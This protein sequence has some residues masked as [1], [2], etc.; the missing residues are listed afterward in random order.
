M[1]VIIDPQSPGA[2]AAPASDVIKDGDTQS[3]TAD[4]IEASTQIPVIVDFWAPWCGPCKQLGPML[5]KLVNQA[6]G[7]VRLVKINID[8]NK[9]LAAQLRV[10]SVP[11]VYAFV[12]GRPVD[13]FVGAQPESKLRAFISQLTGDAHAPL[14]DALEQAQATLDGGDPEGALAIF[15]QI[16]GQDSTNPKA[17]AG[18]IRSCVATGDT[19]SAREVADGL[20]AELKGVTEVAAAIA[21]I[22]LAEQGGSGDS[23]SDLQS[24]VAKE[25]DNH[26]ARYDL[27]V[28]L[29]GAN[30]AEAAVDELLE[31]V[32]RERDWNE[33]AARKQLVKIFDAMGPTHPLTVASRR[34]L[35][36]L[37]FS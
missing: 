12:G 11:M 13:G 15:S 32:R 17:V 5:E 30:R 37:L 8:E 6:A 19:A 35:S 23:I 20:T 26:Q 1:S 25:P 21:A 9:E 2:S 4:V 18:L 22:E 14:D 29:Y 36:S 34:R 27:A 28:A 7:L 10:Q 24:T 33:D 16:L 3:F 31:L